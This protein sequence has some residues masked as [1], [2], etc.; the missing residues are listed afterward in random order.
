MNFLISSLENI[1]FGEALLFMVIGML[2]IIAVLSILVGLL[3]VIRF[4]VEA[5]EKKPKTSACE[6]TAQLPSE[7][8]P[9][10]EEYDEEVV[11][12]I[13]AA[14]TCVLQSESGDKGAPVAPF[15]IK[16]IKHIH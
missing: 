12:A 11:A 7:P 8:L 2:I 5:I 13:T 6:Q 9:K 3:Y 16:K 4:V 1:S 14:V 15:R 10:A